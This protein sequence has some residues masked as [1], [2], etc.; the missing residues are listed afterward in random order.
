[1][2]IM[3]YPI[4]QTVEG[5][6]HNPEWV[7]ALKI[8]LNFLWDGNPND[9]SKTAF[10]C[11]VVSNG[12][13]GESLRLLKREIMVRLGFDEHSLNTYADFVNNVSMVL[14]LS[15]PELDHQTHRY[16]LQDGRRRFMLQLIKEFGG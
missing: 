2:T 15:I 13:G 3:E 7:K 9:K 11:Y 12:L 14:D 8:G 4:P 10:I 6:V 1:M 16:A 5:T